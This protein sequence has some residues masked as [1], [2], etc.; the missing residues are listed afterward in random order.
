MRVR[1]VVVALAV[2]AILVG[3]VVYAGHRSSEMGSALTLPI[4]DDGSVASFFDGGEGNDQLVGIALV[5]LERQYY[6][7]IDPQTPFRGV[8]KAL[9]AYLKSMHVNA[10]LPDEHATGNPS[11]DAAHLEDEVAYAQ[12]HYGKKAGNT[13]ILEQALSGMMD[14]VDD[15]YTVY[16]TPREIRQLTETLNGGNFGGIGV[17]IFALRNH[18]TLIQPIEGLPAD[19]AGI[20]MPLILDA[21]NGTATKGLSI[22]TVQALIRGPAG[23]PVTLRAHAI[24]KPKP[25]R[26]YRIVREIIHVPTVKATMEDGIDYIRLS[27]FGET[28]AREIHAALL[29]GKARGARGYILDLRDNGGGLVNSAVDIVSYFVP[30]GATIVS[31]VDRQGNVAPQLANGATIPGLQPLVI[32]VN[33]YTASASEITAG[34]LQDYH[35]AT[36]VGTQTFGKGVVQSIYG[37]P[38]NEGALKITIARYVTPDGRDIEHRGIRPNVIVN[39]D[40]DPRLI[41]TRADKQLAVAKQE[42]RQL[43]HASPRS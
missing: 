25:V 13:E 33:K 24:E 35:L 32:L 37:M 30:A 40:P 29:D 31:E 22:D 19:E 39:Q 17:Y 28:S 12:T 2:I 7:P 9:T 43:L 42:I 4:A 34:A 8:T 27:E 1:A 6:K 36:L 10:T 11:V 41:D 18:E 26:S 5:Q 16:L 14:S 20:K 21:V 3:A 23:T 38:D 15:P